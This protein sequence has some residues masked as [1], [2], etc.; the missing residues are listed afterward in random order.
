M[1]INY[2]YTINN[3]A[4]YDCI[5]WPTI[6]FKNKYENIT[7]FHKNWPTFNLGLILV[8]LF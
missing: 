8:Y 5:G 6:T 3:H 4:E 1:T 2:D 7:K